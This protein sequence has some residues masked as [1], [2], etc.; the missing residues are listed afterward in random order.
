M[1]NSAGFFFKRSAQVHTCFLEMQYIMRRNM[2]CSSWFHLIIYF[3]FTFTKQLCFR[4]ICLKDYFV[5]KNS[6]ESDEFNNIF[7]SIWTTLFNY[8]IFFNEKKCKTRMV[9]VLFL[10]VFFWFFFAVRSI[11][12]IAKYDIVYDS[13]TSY[14]YMCQIGK[15]NLRIILFFFPVTKTECVNSLT[16]HIH[17]PNWGTVRDGQ[18][19][20]NL[21]ISNN[22]K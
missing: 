13:S 11:R 12:Y 18:F 21:S 14:V 2:S 1:C 22:Y 9:F 3:Y 20:F 4:T 17:N 19:I 6:I 7:F 10:G 5:V 16:R 15:C 8:L